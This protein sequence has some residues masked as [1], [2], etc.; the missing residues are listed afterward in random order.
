MR[1]KPDPVDQPERRR[2]NR[3]DDGEGRG[4]GGEYIP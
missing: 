2:R 3:R 4:V 1:S